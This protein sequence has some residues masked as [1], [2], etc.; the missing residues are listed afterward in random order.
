MT[1]KLP[2]LAL[3][4]IPGVGIVLGQRLLASGASP[5]WG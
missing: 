4:S 5:G 3:R 1:D 2:W